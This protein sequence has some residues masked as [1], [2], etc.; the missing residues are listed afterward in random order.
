MRRTLMI[1]SVAF[2]LAVRV[3]TA[4]TPGWTQV[5][6][7][8]QAGAPILVESVVVVPGSS[9]LY[10]GARSG[11]FRSDDGGADWDNLGQPGG[12][13]TRLLV[14]DPS[15]PE[16]VYAATDNGVFK[17]MDGG[18]TW[19]PS[20]LQD[21]GISALAVDPASPRTL[22][23]GTWPGAGSGSSGSVFKSLDAGQS[24]SKIDELLLDVVSSLGVD[25]LDSSIV[26]AGTLNR[27]VLR[28]GDAGQTWSHADFVSGAVFQVVPDPV[29]SGV[30]YS[31]WATTQYL[32][33]AMPTGTLRRTRD[34]GATWSDVAGLPSAYPGPFAI[35][36]NDAN[37]L[38]SMTDGS[39]YRSIDGA[40]SWSVLAPAPES[41][42][43]AISG[44]DPQY[45]YSAGEGVLRFDL[46]VLPPH[47]DASATTLCLQY[48]RFAVDVEWQQ[49]PLG[50][51]FQGQAIP[52]TAESGY[53]WFF[54][55]D[56]V[57]LMIKVLDGTA[58]NDHFWVLY[59][60]LSDVAYTVTVTDTLTGAK[61]QYVNEQGTLA[62]VAD[63]KAFPGAVSATA[64][65][66]R[67]PNPAVLTSAAASPA[68]VC[69][70]DPTALC[71]EE[72]RFQVRVAWQ[73][74]PDG[75]SFNAAAIPLTGD[76]GYFWFFTDTNVELVVKV[77]DGR[78]INGHFWV[79]YGALSNVQYTITVTDT[80]TGVSQIYEKPQGNLASVADTAAF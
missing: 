25:P 68:V 73:A 72:G 46:A 71:L 28:S 44:G 22:Y 56:N 41:I 10:A 36:P 9:T 64:S 20:G 18:A 30:V 74:A 42:Q 19:A 61:R 57:E 15:A 69:E 3:A 70:P 16:T 67:P 49:T 4:A 17:T 52:V 24:W 33:W 11:V 47:C 75:P 26:F 62:S 51:T 13:E 55:P 77:L 59:G 12:N 79:F 39:L 8:N 60:A 31:R 27:R 5:G 65:N 34:G 50:P 32:G 80:E 6:P 66:P 76:T 40:E 7:F 53:F 2:G 38:Y 1:A 23:A 21:Q 78:A 29:R 14:L 54:G 45:V 35:D 37:I 58:I 48:G 43:L 63:I